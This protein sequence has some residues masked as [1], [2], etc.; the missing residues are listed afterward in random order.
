MHKVACE[1]K[2]MVR[3]TIFTLTPYVPGKPIEEVE[4]ELGIKG[5]I[6]MASNENP[7]GPSPLALEA[8]KKAIARVNI[9]PDSNCFYLKRELASHLG[10]GEENLII[11]NG[12]D[13]ILKLIAETFLNPGDEVIYGWPSFSE[14]E[15]V[16]K[17]MEAKCIAVPLRDDF[18]LDLDA[19]IGNVRS[20]TKLIFIC[21]PNNP[22]GTIVKEKELSDFLERL[23]GDVLVVLDEAYYEYVTAPDYPDSLKFVKEGKNVIVL[24]TF[25]K[26]YGLAGLRIGYGI[27]SSEIISCINRV[28]EPFNVNLL[29]QEAARAAL[30][31]SDHLERSKEL[32]LNGKEYLYKSFERLGLRYVPSEANFIF[33]DTGKD[34]KE[35]FAALLRE[36]VIVRTGDIFGYP[37]YIRVTV[38]TPSENERF[39]RSLEKVLS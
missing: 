29:A 38:G 2:D 9:Y 6:K 24:R 18:T 26:I 15:F 23:P 33:V 35:V 7:L 17:V 34:S 27:A 16:S 1:L 19:I 11:G 12:S 39:V 21:N 5:V 4:R 31:D 30:N 32:V 14:Y 22:T 37:T 28:R 3:P 36:G 25:S 8:L 10:C 13:E 20:K